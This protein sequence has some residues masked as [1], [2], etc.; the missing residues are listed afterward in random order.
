MEI[1]INTVVV[2]I[3]GVIIVGGGIVMVTKLLG[4]G[5]SSVAE[6]STQQKNTLERMMASG[7]LVALTPQN[8]VSLNGK[9]VSFGIGIDNRL[10][11]DTTFR[12]AVTKS[13]DNPPGVGNL[14]VLVLPSLAIPANA[15]D[16]A[17]VAVQKTSGKT[18]PPGIYTFIVNVTYGTPAQV[19]D[20]VRF[21]TVTVK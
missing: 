13:G 17:V 6:L 15:R 18:V 21:F 8:Q 16:T 20:S 12:I 3:L 11:A 10:G 14:S 19:Y 4:G 2:M 5:E 1:A 9:G 7:Q